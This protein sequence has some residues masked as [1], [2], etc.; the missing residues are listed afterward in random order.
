MDK[1]L[2]TTTAICGG[3]LGA[4]VH[5]RLSSHGGQLLDLA[6]EA[7]RV[8]LDPEEGDLVEPRHGRVGVEPLA[9]RE[10]DLLRG[11]RLRAL[12][13]VEQLLVELLPR[14]AADLLD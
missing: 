10:H 9:A 8:S 14:P 11:R 13:G 3:S 6:R 2:A 7:R 4:E 5:G 1:A 12:V